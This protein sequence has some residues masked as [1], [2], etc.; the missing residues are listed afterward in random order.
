MNGSGGERQGN[1]PGAN[2]AYGFGSHDAAASPT[3]P[4]AAKPQAAHTDRGEHE[5]TP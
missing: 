2:R 5:A 4:V 3:R 1:E